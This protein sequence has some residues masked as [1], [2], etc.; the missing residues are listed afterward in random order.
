MKRNQWG[1]LVA[2]ACAGSVNG[3]L[4]AGG[5]M[6]LVPLLSG[7]AKLDEE[8]IFPTS[9]AIILPISIVSLFGS[10]GLSDLDFRNALPYLI[11]SAVGGI[12]C[13]LLGKKIPVKWLHRLLGVLILW[14]GIRYL[15]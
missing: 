5:G 7:L 1:I 2:G 13:G 8:Q 4:G 9:V 12:L 14:G 10:R 11:G 3:L 6:V 15:C